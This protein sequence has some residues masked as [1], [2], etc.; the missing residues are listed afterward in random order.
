MLSFHV[1]FFICTSYMRGNDSNFIILKSKPGALFVQSF[2]IVKFS[3]TPKVPREIRDVCLL[4]CLG[5]IKNVLPLFSSKDTCF[6]RH[7]MLKH[8]VCTSQL[9]LLLHKLMEHLSGYSETMQPS[10]S[11]QDGYEAATVV[12][13]F[14]LILQ[15][16][17]SL[18]PLIL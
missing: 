1:Y 16:N 8:E 15:V 13:I 18:K 11:R 10:T 6:F 9:L 2:F 3:R 4:L 14:F 17:F 5:L 12:T 7:C